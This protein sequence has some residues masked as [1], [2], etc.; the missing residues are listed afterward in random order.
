LAVLHV[1]INPAGDL[2]HYVMELAD[3]L[4]TGTEIDPENYRPKTLRDL[5]D[6]AGRMDAEA[7]A[8]I[9]SDLGEALSALH[10]YGLVHRDIKPGN[11]IFVGGRPKL[12]DVGLVTSEMAA[13]T[14][15]GTAGYVPPE[16]PGTVGAD[17]Y[18]LGKVLYELATGFDRMEFP[19]LPA[20]F[21]LGADAAALKELRCL[22]DRACHNHPRHRYSTAEAMLADLRMLLAGRS[23][24]RLHR[25]E[26]RIRQARRLALVAGLSALV[27]APLFWWQRHQARLVRHM[28]GVAELNQAATA[29]QVGNLGRARSLLAGRPDSLQDR[30]F[31]WLAL[32]H[33]AQGDPSVLLPHSHLPITALGF[34]GDEK[35]AVMD[36]AGFGGL[37]SVPKAVF[38]PF[39][40]SEEQLLGVFQ[41]QFVTV[42]QHGEQVTVSG[43]TVRIRLPK[44]NGIPMLAA[45]AGQVFWISRGNPQWGATWD[46]VSGRL[47]H[48]FQLP[49][50][51]EAWRVWRGC[52]SADGR[53]A[54]LYLVVGA[55]HEL[56]GRL[57][58]LS[59]P[60]G[61]MLQTQSW[62]D[63]ITALALSPDASRLAVAAAATT[64]LHLFASVE[65]RALWRGQ[66]E[67]GLID[68]LA[69][70]PAGARLAMGGTDHLVRAMPL[71]K[72]GQWTQWRGCGSAIRTLAWSKDGSRLAAG[73][74]EGEVRIFA[75][76]AAGPPPREIGGFLRDGIGGVTVSC[77][78][79][80]LAATQADGTV[81]IF[82]LPGF[83]QVARLPEAFEPCRFGAN[84]GQLFTI[85]R[86][87]CL[88]VWHWPSGT[89]LNAGLEAPLGPES[90][91]ITG[92]G[93]ATNGL[94]VVCWADG[95]IRGFRFPA[96]LP[97]WDAA[98]DAG[99]PG[100]A[101]VS[102][103]GRWAATAN[104]RGSVRLIQLENGAVVGQWE[105]GSGPAS[106]AV[107][108]TGTWVAVG[109][110]DG[111][112][113]RFR[114]GHRT[115][116]TQWV[117]PGKV[118]SMA[119]SPDGT[120]LV[121]GTSSGLVQFLD[122]STWEEAVVL[123]VDST[124]AAAGDNQVFNLEFS[125]DGRVLL[126]RTSRGQIRLW[127]AESPE[128]TIR[129]TSSHVQ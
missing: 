112:V 22:I 59:L 51:T 126:A 71:S 85:D 115:V 78:G 14:F 67:N 25:I 111:T 4:R 101:A 56:R 105:A 13:R 38:N 43:S 23:V 93:V 29:L 100:Y 73:S 122:T 1:G 119:V 114:P 70:D 45:E 75:A 21:D 89:R 68:A 61:E 92:L 10:G 54:A 19:R 83:A 90:G 20:D 15:V 64:N 106:V 63:P 55:G 103:D 52:V 27:L 3:D 28:L 129:P 53:M 60:D 72:P 123:P 121:V 35:L 41:Q 8:R 102:P 42:A 113:R 49:L 124:F 76:D 32:R 16:G 57:V 66:T 94:A 109:D 44:T 81:S 88:Q 9:G 91:L 2:F 65:M 74:L 5:H 31:E 50:W 26:H 36:K 108:P 96:T 77:D 34:V 104:R 17:I 11:I 48:E 117:A 97:L 37:W 33:E 79:Q 125:A 84:P 24:R 80:V 127:R 6:P 62:A 47:L 18:A 95:R 110:T 30:G 46:L 69:F 107:A 116:P 58:L 87:G 118:E 12:A 128:S 86:Q 82:S 40:A 39:G 99:N 98:D 120:R 7:V